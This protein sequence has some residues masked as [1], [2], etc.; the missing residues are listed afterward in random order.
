MRLL[1]CLMLSQ[2]VLSVSSIKILGIF[3]FQGKSHFFVFEPY[4]RELAR[5]GHDVTVI[6]YF[7]QKQVIL[8][9]TDI[10]LAEKGKIYENIYQVEQT[11]FSKIEMMSSLFD[12]I[13][14]NCKTLLTDENVQNLWKSQVKFDL[15]LVEA[16]FGDCGLGLAYKLEAPVIA[17]TSHAMMPHHFDRFALPYQFLEMGP[18]TTLIQRFVGT[19]SLEF[20]KWIVQWKVQSNEQSILAKYFHDI[21]PLEEL[22]RDIKFILLYSHYALVGPKAL[23]ENVK[24]VGGYHVAKTKP[25]P[26][27][28]IHNNNYISHISVNQWLPG[29][30]SV[31]TLM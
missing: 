6:S 29:G 20:L 30:R 9:Y 22:G 14:E 11:F 23:P 10:S 7:P 3:P 17:L 15:V 31:F 27:V 18:A 8:N 26:D 12:N 24:E 16:F 4:L 25:L 19:V 13:L 28:S 1:A 2:T 21:P 5:R